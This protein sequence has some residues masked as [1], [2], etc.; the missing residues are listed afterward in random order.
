MIGATTKRSAGTRTFTYG[1]RDRQEDSSAAGRWLEA[2]CLIIVVMIIIGIYGA[3][4]RPGMPWADDWATYIQ[5]ALNLLHGTR[6]STTGYIV[7]PDLDI[8]PTAYPPLY[9]LS[10]VVPIA[11]WGIDFDAIREFQLIFWA[12]F[13]VSAYLLARIRLNFV[14]SLLVVIAVGLSPYFLEFKDYIA[15]EVLFLALLYITFVTSAWIENV[16]ADRNAPTRSDILLGALIALCIATRSVGLILLPTLVVYDVLRFRR[17]RRESVIAVLIAGASFLGQ[18]VLVDS[19]NDYIISIGSNN[20]RDLHGLGLQQAPTGSLM[21]TLT[22]AAAVISHHLSAFVVEFSRFWGQGAY[23][24]LLPRVTSVVFGLLATL[25]FSRTVMRNVMLCDVFAAL[26]II[27]SPGTAASHGRGTDGDATC[28]A[29]LYVCA[30]C[31]PR[32]HLWFV[33][34]DRHCGSRPA[35]CNM[36]P[37]TLL[38]PA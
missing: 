24:S 11:L 5:D 9:P 26:Y 31:R 13:L 30:A 21:V 36:F 20:R 7:N 10:L 27:D 22:E 37:E 16:S 29:V 17:V 12:T 8:G 4:I 15:S 14:G 32:F 6:Y 33:P 38:G 19:F 2:A 18:L 25:G 34:V 28:T 23:G 1:H 35:G 3:F